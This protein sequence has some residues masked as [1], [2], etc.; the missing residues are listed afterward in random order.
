ME[1]IDGKMAKGTLEI[2]RTINVMVKALL[3]T[4]M[5]AKGQELGK[6]IKE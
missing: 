2:G 3:N 1:L 6:M 5:V 4:Q